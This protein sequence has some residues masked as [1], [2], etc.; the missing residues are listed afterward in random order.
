M[1]GRGWL[2]AVTADLVRHWRHFAAASVGIILG[3]AALAFFLA[4][5]LKVRELLLVQVFPANHLEVAPR[6]ADIDLFALRLDL[7]RDTLDTAILVDLASI[8]GVDAVYPKM[9]LTVPALASG[10]DSIFGSGLQ[11]EIVADGID[12]DLVADEFGDAFREVDGSWTT[13]PCSRDEQCGDD[14]YCDGTHF[15]S[16]GSCQPYIPVLVSPYVVELYNGAFRRA[17]GLPKINPDALMGLTFEM[18]FGASTFRPSAFPPIR[19]RMRLAGVSDKAIPLGVTLPLGEVRRLNMALS[20]P[21]AGEQFHSAVIEVQSKQKAP[22]VFDAVEAMGL[23][24][25]DRGA[26]RAAFATAVIMVVLALVGGVLIAVAAAH[27]MHVFYLVV[28][29]R[30]REIG[31]LRAVGARRGDIRVL[32]VAESAV[33]GLVAGLVGLV[34]AMAAGAAANAFAASQVPDFPFKP[35]SFF[36]FS[37]WLLAAV[38]T[39]AVVACV[40]GVLPPA[41]R[42]ASGDPSEALAGR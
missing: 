40:I 25:R 6:S 37:P 39:L 38:L 3:V 15:F 11:T 16:G 34:L 2:R 1:I 24:V 22:A 41:F 7:G 27:I 4:L 19:K 13:T 33:V 21:A 32:L 18:D 12:P 42:A 9:R 23:E 35:E 20:G 30:R 14:A 36:A 10:G 31:L 28:M 17:Y 29:V 26:R 5:G 8:D